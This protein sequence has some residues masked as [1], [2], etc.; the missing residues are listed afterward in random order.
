[1]ARG[2]IAQRQAELKSA[3]ARLTFRE[4]EHGRMKQLRDNNTIPEQVVAESAAKLEA[5]RGE[6]SGAEAAVEN[7]KGDTDLKQVK[8]LQAE[9]AIENAR[10]SLDSAQIGLEMV[11]PRRGQTRI[12]AL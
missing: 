11:R 7:A 6:V 2:V 1:M 8:I 9:S 10:Y 5:A 3:R 12:V 4:A